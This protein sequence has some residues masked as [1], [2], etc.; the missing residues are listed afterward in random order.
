V[1]SYLTST[2][3]RVKHTQTDLLRAA[4]IHTQRW[5]PRSSAL[6]FS[7]KME[8]IARSETPGGRARLLPMRHLHR[9][10]LM[11]QVDQ[12]HVIHCRGTVWEQT[13]C[14]T[15]S[16]D[17]THSSKDRHGEFS[18]FIFIYFIGDQGEGRVASICL[19]PVHIGESIYWIFKQLTRLGK[20]PICCP[21]IRDLSND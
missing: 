6:Y 8:S 4:L 5:A 12:G 21:K 14:Y 15:Y 17:A 20:L 1:F 16:H 9:V 11:K 13:Q 18:R 19:I 2:D 3:G 7:L 10:H